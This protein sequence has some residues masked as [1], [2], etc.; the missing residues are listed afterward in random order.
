VDRPASDAVRSANLGAWISLEQS[1]IVLL[2]P[3]ARG[4]RRG[5][6][7]YRRRGSS[8]F[9]QDMHINLGRGFVGFGFGH[10]YGNW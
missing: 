10:E 6:Q 5:L 1:V 8:G 7:L 9:D 2:P 3:R 4:V